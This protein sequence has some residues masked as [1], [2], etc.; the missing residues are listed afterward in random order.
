MC[1][2]LKVYTNISQPDLKAHQNYKLN[3][4]DF[5]IIL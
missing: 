1:Y 3:N 2:Q 5:Y 4:N